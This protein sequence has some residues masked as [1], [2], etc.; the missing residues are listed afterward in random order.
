TH[1]GPQ[2]ARE[3]I[4]TG[5]WLLIEYD[6]HKLR[7]NHVPKF[8]GLDEFLKKQGRFK[9]M[10]PN[11]YRIMEDHIRRRYKIYQSLSSLNYI[12]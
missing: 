8:K 6:K 5:F 9:H 11:Q 2:L 10:T 7:I 3:A 4:D 1:L 12:Q